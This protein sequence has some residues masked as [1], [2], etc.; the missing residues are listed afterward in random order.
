MHAIRN[1]TKYI[2]TTNKSAKHTIRFTIMVAISAAK[3]LLLITGQYEFACSPVL[4][5]RDRVELRNAI[6]TSDDKSPQA[7]GSKHHC[8]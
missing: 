1:S 7:D 4:Q 2:H 6:E 3:V 5:S 8:N